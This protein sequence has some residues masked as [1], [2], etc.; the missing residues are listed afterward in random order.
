MSDEIDVDYKKD[1][2]KSEEE[3]IENYGQ[4]DHVRVYAKKTI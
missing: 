1:E 3:R 2:I 4:F